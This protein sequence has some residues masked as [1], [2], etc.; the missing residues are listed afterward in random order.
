MELKMLLD[1]PAG[2]PGEAGIQPETEEQRKQSE[3]NIRSSDNPE[4]CDQPS[5]R[6]SLTSWEEDGKT[7][8]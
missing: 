5:N 3:N 2:A 7:A 4:T 6:Y 8:R 1:A